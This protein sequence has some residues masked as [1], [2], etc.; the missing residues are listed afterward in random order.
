MAGDEDGEVVGGHQ[1]ADLAGMQP[2][3][4]GD[5]VVGAGL[6]QGD[7]SKRFE[8]GHLCRREVE[9]AAEVIGVGKGAGRPGEILVQPAGSLPAGALADVELGHGRA[10]PDGPLD[11]ERPG[12][13]LDDQGARLAL[14]DG[15]RAD[16]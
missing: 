2:G 16:R 5:V 15:E 8:D 9:P 10:E 14:D 7:L 3:G 1:P 11:G 6:A 4:A 13:K 12:R